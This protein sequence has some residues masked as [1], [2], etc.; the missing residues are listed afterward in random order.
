MS[1]GVV[2]VALQQFCEF[3][4]VPKQLLREAGWEVRVNE[5][6]RRLTSEDLIHVL[7]DA[8]AVV[9]GVEPYDA[10]VLE[11]L[12]RLQCIS[13]CGVGTDAIDLDV[14]RRKGIA[15]YTTPDEVVEPVAQMT[16]AMILALARNLPQYLA[17][18]RQGAW[19]KRPGWLLSEWTVGLVGFGRIGRTV[20]RYLRVFGPRV[21]VSDP[22]VAPHEV[23]ETA[24]WCPLPRLLAEADVVSLHANRPRQEGVL[25][26]RA[27]LGQMK[28]GSRL[29]NTS[30]GYLVDEQALEA[31][32]R[33][34]HLAA[35]AF[36][37]FEQEPYTGPLTRFPHVLCTPHVASLTRAS[38]A[39]MERRA[40]QHLLEHFT[41]MP[42]PS[43]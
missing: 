17:A 41:R 16:V 1:R 18:S 35:A 3:E 7:R 42:A 37:V 20:E 30:R 34:G 6:G 9:A 10:A 31:A 23:P 26:G 29:I 14:A 21:L 43:R 32:L 15:V 24:H 27:E 4:P 5:L 36:D 28:A 25:M 22:F 38:R 19:V 8:E 13:R 40:V 12:P 39:A 33:S 11:A 2:Y